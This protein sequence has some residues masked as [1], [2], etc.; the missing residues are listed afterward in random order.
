MTPKS[1]RKI[2]SISFR[3]RL[4][5]AMLRWFLL[6]VMLP[7]L[8]LMMG[9]NVASK[10]SIVTCPWI[11]NLWRMLERFSYKDL[12]PFL[13]QSDEKENTGSLFPDFSL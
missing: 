9:T 8:S 12:V 5:M 6:L 10:R 1:I 13:R 11:R 4:L 2:Q 3:T 7:S